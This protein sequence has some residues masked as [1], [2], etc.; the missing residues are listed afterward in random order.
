ME[1]AEDSFS[2]LMEEDS[3]ISLEFTMDISKS[4]MILLVICWR[5]LSFHI[6]IR[7]KELVVDCLI[8]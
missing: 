5:K 2:I 7:T 8:N 4:M 1:N 3:G 6:R